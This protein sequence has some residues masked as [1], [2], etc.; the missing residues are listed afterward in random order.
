MD[1]VDRGAWRVQDLWELLEVTTA[2]NAQVQSHHRQMT[3]RLRCPRNLGRL[4][5]G[6][7]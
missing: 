1:R 5:Q 6:P 7:G 2:A 3:H 4:P